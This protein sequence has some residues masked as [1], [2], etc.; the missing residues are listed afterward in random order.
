MKS[1]DGSF[2]EAVY[3]VTK[4]IPRGKVATYGDIARLAGRPRAAR[5]VGFFMKTNPYAPAVPCHRVIASDGALT[6]YSG[7]GGLET[8]ARMLRAEGVAFRG[9]RVDLTTS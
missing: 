3:A 7:R 9:A 1:N 2:R 8:K 4:R 5:V 6:G